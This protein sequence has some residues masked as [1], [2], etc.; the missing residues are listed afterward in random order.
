MIGKSDFTEN[1]QKSKLPEKTVNSDNLVAG[2]LMKVLESVKQNQPQNSSI[3]STSEGQSVA[4]RPNES[5]VIESN[6]KD[7]QIGFISYKIIF[8]LKKKLLLN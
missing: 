3:T 4:T 8:I 5:K 2:L 6:E 1:F 7:D